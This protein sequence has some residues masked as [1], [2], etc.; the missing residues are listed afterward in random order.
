M[1][2]K[3]FLSI[4]NILYMLH[5]PVLFIKFFTTDVTFSSSNLLMNTFDMSNQAFF[6]CH[7][8][9]AYVASE[10]GLTIFRMFLSQLFSVK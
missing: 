3:I 5:H 6:I 8:G 9:A 7:G 1:T 2:L 10:N 4:M